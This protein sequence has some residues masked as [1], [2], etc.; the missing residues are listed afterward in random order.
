[1]KICLAQTRPVS[2]DVPSNISRHHQLVTFAAACGSEFILFPELSITG[3]EPALGHTLAT[4]P[5]DHRFAVFQNSSN[6]HNIAIAFGVPLKTEIRPTISLLVFQPR[7]PCL[8]YSKQYLHPDEAPYFTAGNSNAGLLNGKNKLALAICYEISVREH[9]ENAYNSGA[10]IYLASVAKSAEGVRK[11]GERLS[12]IAKE[13]AMTVCMANCTGL[14]DGM[15]CAGRSAA[16]NKR[17][18]LL[19]QLDDSSEVLLLL[20]TVAGKCQVHYFER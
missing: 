17:G 20:D 19:A 6:F 9:A 7:Q 12:Q 11:A 8:T 14:N 1:M 5:E 10:E 15:V 3:Y 4:T 2:G 18:E 16:W 13:Y